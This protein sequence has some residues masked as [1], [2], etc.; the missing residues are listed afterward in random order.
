M[1]IWSQ[2]IWS[3][4]FGR[5]FIWSQSFIWSQLVAIG[6]IWSHLVAFGRNGSQLV[7]IGHNT[8]RKHQWPYE[9][10]QLFAYVD[11][12]CRHVRPIQEHANVLCVQIRLGVQRN[13]SVAVCQG[14]EEVERQANANPL[15]YCIFVR[16]FEYLR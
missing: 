2:F 7:A 12:Q 5:M 16:E 6:R 4:I 8:L 9:D 3:H 15:S 13:A 10:G 1:L 11:D 14:Q